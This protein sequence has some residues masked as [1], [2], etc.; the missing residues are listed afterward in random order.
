[1]NKDSA[2]SPRA[3]RRILLWLT[4]LVIGLS[5]YLLGAWAN[6]WLESAGGRRL[7]QRELSKG[8]G[9][10]VSLQGEYG[11]R[12]LP[13]LEIAGTGLEVRQKE[14]GGVFL[15][16][17]NFSAEVELIPLLNKQL[18]IASINLGEGFVDLANLPSQDNADSD[19]GIAASKT[20]ATLPEL[21]SL[22]MSNFSIR[23]ADAAYRVDIGELELSGFR[24]GAPASLAVK[25]GLFSD[26]SITAAV[27]LRGSL[28]IEPS[29]LSTDLRIDEMEVALDARHIDGMV[30]QLRWDKPAERVEGQFE[31][32]ADN[33]SMRLQFG[34]TA[35]QPVS[36]TM[37]GEYLDARLQAPLTLGL[38]FGV[39][40]EQVNLEDLAMAM[41]SQEVDGSGCFRFDE[42]AGLHLD[43]A[44]EELDVDALAPLFTPGEGGDTDMS[45][46]YGV[47]MHVG[48]ARL[49]GAVA[50]DV[51]LQAG[52]EPECVRTTEI[53]P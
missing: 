48:T 14:G 41:D 15:Y 13:R 51:L 43:L 33:Q 17:R 47:K 21:A 23:Y 20:P 11:L 37:Q 22:N 25:A 38:K 52:S 8:L 9:L 50:E 24:A 10:P 36:G 29:S 12:I 3:K 30:A 4:L 26:E 35:S 45:F 46:V 19:S 18:R 32:R 27:K 7:L 34:L 6:A 53:L 49:S 5:F 16:S 31:W 44:A 2:K 40:D 39:L 28:T 1:M 42:M